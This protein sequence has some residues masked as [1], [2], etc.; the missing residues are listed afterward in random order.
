MLILQKTKNQE[1][2]N[3]KIN[4]LIKREDLNLIKKFLLKNESINNNKAIKF[5]LDYY[6][7]METLTSRV[8]L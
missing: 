8:N 2:T 4:Y 7:K 5:Y 3:F 6:L 1:F